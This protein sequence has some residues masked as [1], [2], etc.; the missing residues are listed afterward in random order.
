MQNH[1]CC[2]LKQWDTSHVIHTWFRIDY[3]RPVGIKHFMQ[4]LHLI[5][6]WAKW[7]QQL[8][9][10]ESLSWA[11]LFLCAWQ[12][13]RNCRNSPHSSR[14]LT[15]NR[16]FSICLLKK[17]ICRIFIFPDCLSRL[18]LACWGCQRMQKSRLTSFCTD[19]LA[20]H[21]KWLASLI[22]WKTGEQTQWLERS[23]KTN[24]KG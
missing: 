12:W 23:P 21:R 7:R 4:P 22:S 15:S 14:Y 9:K 20:V 24:A 19:N 16:I 11:L 17:L 18:S 2:I 1:G 6:S 13:L 5:S 3:P 10:A 8:T